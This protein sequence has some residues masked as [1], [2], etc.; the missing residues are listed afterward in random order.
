MHHHH[1]LEHSPLQDGQ[2]AMSESQASMGLD[3]RFFDVSPY[4]GR[5]RDDAQCDRDP[6]TFSQIIVTDH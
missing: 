2:V 6:C 1:F 5:I 3:E 4:L